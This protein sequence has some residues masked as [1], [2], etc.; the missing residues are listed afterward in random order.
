MPMRKRKEVQE[1]LREMIGQGS[2]VGGQGAG[3]GEDGDDKKGLTLI[4]DP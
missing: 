4:P 1:M 3:F 2:G